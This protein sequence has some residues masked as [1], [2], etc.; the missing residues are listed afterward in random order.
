M[1][2]VRRRS[3]ILALLLGSV[4]MLFG[5][6]GSRELWTQEHRWAEIVGRMFYYQDF[7]HPVLNGLNYYDKPLLSYW[8]VAFFSFV[9]GD[10]SL[11]TLRLPSAC[12]GLI[13]IGSL[14]RIG[15]H[16]KD[17]NF[18]ILAAGM[19]LTTYYF[20][21]WARVSSA[22]MLNLAGTLLAI[23]WYF[24]KRHSTSFFG[25]TIFFIICSLTALCKGLIGPAI[26]ALAV[27]PDV[28]LQ[29]TWK[30]H[31]NLSFF[32]AILPA[33]FIYLLPFYLSMHFGDQTYKKNGMWDVYRENV[34]RYL[35][36]FDHKEPFYVYFFYLPLYLFPWVFF[37]FPA[38]F[39]LKKRWPQLST[40]SRWMCWVTL[41]IF[42]FFTLSGSRRSYYILPLIPFAILLTADW[43]S[44]SSEKILHAKRLMLISF[45][46]FI[47]I[48]TIFLPLY[49][50][51]GGVNTFASVIKPWSNQPMILLDAEYKVRFYLH[52]PPTVPQFDPKSP[53]GRL[54]MQ[55]MLAD[56]PV[57][58]NLPQNT[59]FISRKLHGPVLQQILKNYK[60]VTADPTWLEK[61]FRKEDPNSPIAFIPNFLYH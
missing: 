47:F 36:P 8:L 59:I 44:N 30:K 20:I 19:L 57:L 58:A 29:K 48:F 46:I 37:F 11:W 35:K 13:A 51:K 52:L 10:L 3:K 5:M 32:L 1:E 55:K 23:A 18:G 56:W 27:I 39:S 61:I 54:T 49:Y 17:K 40:S 21:F 22:D 14:Y 7:F 2:W 9:F 26:V 50:S 4:V 43:I 42:L 31:C 41:M 38:L 33:I 60:M 25:Y 16:L 12:A 45:T 15:C 34:L 28:I 53:R 24:E 6:L